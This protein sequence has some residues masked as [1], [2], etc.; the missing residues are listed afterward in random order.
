MEDGINKLR[1]FISEIQSKARVM[2]NNERILN[3]Q[4]GSWFTIH[5]LCL[6]NQVHE[7]CATVFI[8]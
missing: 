8:I 7:L 3:D 4:L 5:E 2:V 6:G 1:R